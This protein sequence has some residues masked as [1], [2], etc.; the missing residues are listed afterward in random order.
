[1]LIV[2]Y[3]MPKIEIDYSKTIIYKLVCNDLTVTDLYVGHTTNFTKRKGKH[4]HAC[5][6][7]NDRDYNFKVYQFIRENGGW[8]NW[9]MIQIEEHCCNNRREAEARERYWYEQLK[10]NLNTFYPARTFE[11]WVA[12]NKAELKEY[13]KQYREA[14]KEKKI[15]YDK[16]RYK[17]KKVNPPL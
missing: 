15:Q 13:S 4:K 9:N 6:N 5:C 8:E 14:N 3:I 7:E 10:A 1:V 16:E 2:S 11:E 17:A 12:L